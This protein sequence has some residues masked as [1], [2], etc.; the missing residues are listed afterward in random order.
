MDFCCVCTVIVFFLFVV[1]LR[2][3]YVLK[4]RKGHG[5]LDRRKPVKV[6]VVAGSGTPCCID[7][8]KFYDNCRNSRALIG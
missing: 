1:I 7:R 4:K 6:M 8:R 3:V 5:P 2:T